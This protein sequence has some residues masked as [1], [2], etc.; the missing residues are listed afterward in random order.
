ML[1]TIH[2]VI[3]HKMNALYILSQVFIVIAYGLFMCSY[4]AKTRIKVLAY[5]SA[6][7]LAEG[8]AYIL[9]FAWSGVAMVAIAS[10]RNI[11][12]WAQARITEKH[13]NFEK[14]NWVSLTIIFI[15]QTLAGVATYQ[16]FLSL[17]SLISSAIFTYSLW[18]KD[19]YIYNIL[20][21]FSCIFLII[22]NINIASWF[23]AILESMVMLW[24]IFQIFTKYTHK[25]F[26]LVGSKEKP[27]EQ[28][29][30]ETNRLPAV[31][32]KNDIKIP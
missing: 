1:K 19:R 20:G 3:L 18:Q 6:S 28:K 4:I 21:V 17:F 11:L 8:T 7:L 9:L 2:C 25:G 16:G 12:F 32:Y 27:Q 31:I 30:D 10:I 23:G 14:Y 26:V 22:Y 29:P 24:I 13:P 15:L 5:S